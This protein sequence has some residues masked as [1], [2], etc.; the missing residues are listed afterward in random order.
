MDRDRL[1]GGLVRRRVLLSELLS[2]PGPGI[3]EDEKRPGEKS[4]GTHSRK[5]FSLFGEVS[6]WRNYY[7]NP[8]CSTGFL[9][10]GSWIL[11]IVIDSGRPACPAC[12]RLRPTFLR[13]LRKLRATGRRSG[14]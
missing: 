1:E 8:I 6:L 4:G 7:Y 11:I 2:D 9:V 12:A 13:R 10:L 3:E 5:I 14:L